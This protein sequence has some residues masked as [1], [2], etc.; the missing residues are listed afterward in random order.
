MRRFS[1]SP[2]RLAWGASLAFLAAFGSTPTARAGYVVGWGANIDGQVVVPAGNDFVAVAGGC[3]HSIALKDDGSV[4]AW[5]ADGEGQAD[6]PVAATYDVTA[7]SAGGHHNLALKSDGSLVAWGNLGLPVADFQ[8]ADFVAVAAGWMFN[9]A[10]KRDG[11]I[12]AWDADGVW[13][14]EEIPTE[15]GFVDIAAGWWHGLAL[16]NDGSLVAWGSD[17]FEPLVTVS[18]PGN[19]FVAFS[20]GWKHNL[21]VRADGSL[22][23]WG[24]NSDGQVEPAASID[25]SDL[26]AVAAGDTHGAGLKADGSLVAW[27]SYFQFF[28]EGETPSTNDFVALG[29]DAGWHTLA[30]REP[31][32]RASAASG[33]WHLPT[34]W[35][36]ETFVPDQDHELVVGNHAITVT[37]DGTAFALLW[38]DDDAE[39]LI[40][41]DS[42]LT[43]LNYAN[44]ARGSLDLQGTLDVGLVRVGA[45]AALNVDGVLN[46][47]ATPGLRGGLAVEL[48]RTGGSQITGDGDVRL[49]GTLTLTASD[50]V[51]PED[52]AAWGYAVG[53]IVS[54]GETGS[55]QGSFANYPVSPEPAEPDSDAHPIQHLGYGVFTADPD[56]D[57]LV[58]EYLPQ[59]VAIDLFQA[60]D[61]D[62]DGNGAID[63]GDIENILA[64]N[65]LMNGLPA[66]WTQG[67]FDGDGLASSSDI[68]AILA[69]GLFGRGRYVDGLLDEPAVG[70][71]G[72]P[73]GDATIGSAMGR[74][75]PVSTGSLVPEPSSVAMLAAGGLG[76]LWAVWRRW[77]RI[78]GGAGT[79]HR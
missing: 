64:A 76:L 75:H 23:A 57:D 69:T 47:N 48:D 46:L 22:V 52:N 70:L 32:S 38:E 27:G 10:L 65:R 55:V 73:T 12:V 56:G 37:Q 41:P 36:D 26:V 61:G 4:V 77:R 19:D 79:R 44:L 15:A 13:T 3:S 1:G 17:F 68:E 53:T 16:R 21:A 30:I 58:L 78:R 6:I 74:L 34:T 66:D 20:A 63:G 40:D 51:L 2:R 60:A 9:A 43:I 5:G 33:D 18:P 49:A 50:K 7:I 11:R 42:T 45:E 71:G 8:N 25:V 29:K 72:M 67:D 14:G 28:P 54:T 39:V 35:N 31:P 59:S 24:S 62:T